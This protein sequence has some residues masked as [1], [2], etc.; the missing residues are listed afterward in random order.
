MNL[1]EKKKKHRQQMS[2]SIGEAICSIQSGTDFLSD[3]CLQEA[4][5]TALKIAQDNLIKVRNS[6]WY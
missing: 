2:R 3:P 1:E 5:K 6:L 4:E